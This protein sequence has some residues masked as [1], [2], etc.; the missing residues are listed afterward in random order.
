MA[1]GE[2]CELCGFEWDAVSAGE[3]PGRLSAAADAF[4]RVVETAGPPGLVRPSPERWTVLEYAAHLR[5]V[6][7]SIRERII[8]AAIIDE[9]TGTPIYRDE[10][11]A[12]RLYEGDTSEVVASELATSSRLFVRTFQSLAPRFERREFFY[13]PAH[14]RKVT[15][16]WA[17]AQALHECEHH[18]RDIEQNLAQLSTST[19]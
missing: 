10:R 4:V 19:P 18:L 16:L 11:V 8:T 15:I 13:S 5:D 7:L 2:L 17:G 3:I 14:P 6:L 12:L 9:P 1:S